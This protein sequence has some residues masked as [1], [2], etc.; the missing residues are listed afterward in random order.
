MESPLAMTKSPTD[1]QLPPGVTRSLWDYLHRDAIAEDYDAYFEHHALLQLDV[2]VV[3]R[4]VNDTPAL[5][6]DPAVLA[7]L[8]CGTARA[9]IPFIER[10]HQGLAIDLSSK[11]LGVA[12][13][14]SIDLPGMQCL[15]ANLVDLGAVK[16]GVVD[17]AF[18]LFS[19]L[20]MIRGRKHRAAALKEAFRILRPGGRLVLHVHNF[21]FN[22]YD[23]GGW[24][25]VPTDLARPF[26]NRSFERGDRYF[27]YRGVPNMFLHSFTAGEL[28]ELV[29]QAGLVLEE[30][31]PLSSTYE[32]PLRSP[33][34]VPS[35]R[36]IGW[37]VVA[38][39]PD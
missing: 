24:R 9:L 15:R 35:L 23:P 5:D 32:G 30:R 25:R 34:F 17:V 12:R 39:K 6:G 27:Y 16:E 18:C 10:G 8:G 13:R 29:R 19:T 3:E 33:S 21:W 22:L 37:I 7:D 2:D 38:R 26:W 31:I 28:S 4:V 36:A 11:M 14:K 1:W 20:G